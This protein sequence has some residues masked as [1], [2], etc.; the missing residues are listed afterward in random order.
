MERSLE[1]QEPE[2]LLCDCA[3]HSHG[4]LLFKEDGEVKTEENIPKDI[5]KV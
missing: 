2:N 1:F 5:P 4:L 3:L